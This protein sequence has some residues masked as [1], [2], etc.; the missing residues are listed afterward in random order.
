MIFILLTVWATGA[1]VFPLTVHVMVEATLT[2]EEIISSLTL[3]LVWPLALA[4]GLAA[5]GRIRRL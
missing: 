3:A 2:R 4:Y 5:K 1:V